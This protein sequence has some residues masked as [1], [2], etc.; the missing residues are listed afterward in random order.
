MVQTWEE[1]SAHQGMLSD[2]EA[3][4]KAMDRT[5]ENQHRYNSEH[6]DQDADWI[7]AEAR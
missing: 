1:P 6:E 2:A 5:I 7:H 3:Q 4:S